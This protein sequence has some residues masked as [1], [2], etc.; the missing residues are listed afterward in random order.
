VMPTYSLLRR[1][2]SLLNAYQLL[3][4]RA[5]RR[6]FLSRWL[7]PQPMWL[8]PDPRLEPEDLASLWCCA[9]DLGVDTTVMMFHS[10]E[11]MPAGSPFRPDAQSVQRLLRCL[12]VFF[13]FVARQGGEF[14][15]LTPMAAELLSQNR[16]VTKPL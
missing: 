3:P 14:S 4:A 8:M 9:A 16:L 15:A 1:H 2:H 10:S 13:E 12:D 5:V 6:L 7:R 11:L